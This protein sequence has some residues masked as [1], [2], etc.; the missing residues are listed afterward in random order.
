MVWVSA[1]MG[2][3]ESL[4]RLL[5]EAPDLLGSPAADRAGPRRRP[6]RAGRHRHAG[7]PLPRLP[8][9]RQAGPGW[10]RAR[11]GT[12]EAVR[13]RGPASGW[14]GWPPRSRAPTRSRSVVVAIDG[15]L[16]VDE[17]QGTWLEQ[18]FHSLRQH[19]L[20]RHVGDP[21]QHH[22][23][24]R[25]RAAPWLTRS[26][27][28]SWRARPR[29]QRRHR[30]RRPGVDLGRGGRRSHP[31]RR[32]AR[33]SRTAGTARRGPARERARVRLPARR[34]RPSP[35][36]W[37]SASTPPVEARSSL[38]TSATPTAPSCSPT[39]P[40]SPCS[41]ASMSAPPGPGGRSARLAAA[42]SAQRGAPAPHP[43]ARARHVVRAPLHVGIHRSAQGG[44]DE[45]G[46]CGPHRRGIGAALRPERRALLRHAALPRQRVAGQP[47]SRSGRRFVDRAE[48][49]VLRVDVHPRRSPARGDVVQLRRPRAVVHPRPAAL[50]RRRRQP[51]RVL[52]RIGGVAARFD[53]SSGVVSAA[54][55]PRATARARVA[56]SSSPSRACLAKPSAGPPRAPTWS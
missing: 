27:S 14:P 15:H 53:A 17:P 29:P 2:L 40:R 38:A 25:A 47:V 49:Q 24:A 26:P 34:R 11:A 41:T 37:S 4:D 5:A 6:D 56:W 39:R 1:V 43:A 13:Q 12:D 19:D 23:R 28:C 9:L 50:A 48:A 10:H 20:G 51:A 18:Y 21:A 44:E 54:T 55:S 7:G 45:P 35:A 8:G 32:A 30:H 31:P 42:R 46:S 52:P 33:R 16:A 3:E 22:R 36:A